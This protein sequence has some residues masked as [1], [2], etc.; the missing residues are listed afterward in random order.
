MAYLAIARKY[1]PSTFDEMVGQ[2]HVTRTLR[3]AILRQRV[4]HA[5]LFC[6]ARGVGKTT[7]ARA[8]AR[9]LCCTVSTTA[10]PCDACPSCKAILAGNSPDL[11]EIDGASNN[12]VDDVRELR[13]SVRYPPSTGR[14]RIYLID[15]VHMLSNAA[16]NAL[17]KTL[18]EPPPHVVFLFATTEADKLPETI[19][20]RV[21]RF[22]FR[23]IP[24]RTV[25]DRLRSIAAGEGAKLSDAGLRMI[26]QAGEGSMRDAQ[27]L[28]DKVISFAIP[29][30]N[31]PSGGVVP[32]AAIAETL[33]LVDRALLHDMLEGMLRGEV[34]KCLDVVARV[35]DYG[36]DPAR[37][38]AELLDVLRDATFLT[39]SGD[40]RAQIEL[41]DE[42]CAELKRLTEGV[43]HDTLVRLF[44]A[45][46][47]THEQVARAPRPRAVLE[48]SLARLTDTRPLQPVGALVARLE[49]LERRLRQGGAAPSPRDP[50]RRTSGPAAR[51]DRAPEAA[52]PRRPRAPRP[53]LAEEASDEERFQALLKALATLDPPM[54][55]LE[56]GITRREGETL[57]V[58][59][60]AGRR[61]VEA[62]RAI[63]RSEV[64]ELVAACYGPRVSL[65]VEESLSS[66]RKDVDPALEQ[67][68]LT[69]PTCQRLMRTLSPLGATLFAVEPDSGG[70]P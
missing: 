10:E 42:E 52:R 31:D 68:V 33:G 57:V 25:V 39:I 61:L 40:L 60:D 49:Q 26:A 67:T 13:E 62:R 8:F 59:V 37:F 65:R 15:E 7:A 14:Y 44:H 47:E 66:R 27:S 18:E 28:L 34:A 50:P 70:T 64:A 24:I 11:T 63:Q 41:S 17:L 43:P 4:H 32:D 53:E 35:H 38:V 46:L 3:N 1:R 48:M 36:H 22:D 9:A 29:S 54:N 55:A 30:T 51:S 58:T 5:Y 20:S 12:S 16:F 19:L 69:D 23:R 6:G 56:G 2:D 21:Q 45:V